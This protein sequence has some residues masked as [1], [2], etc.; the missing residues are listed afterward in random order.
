MSPEV[1]VGDRAGKQVSGWH[2]RDFCRGDDSQRFMGENS[3][4]STHRDGGRGTRRL[5]R[6][7]NKRRKRRT[8]LGA[9]GFTRCAAARV[10]REAEVATNVHVR[11]MDL[12]AFGRSGLG[13]GTIR[14]AQG[15]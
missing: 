9:G 8:P 14:R 15:A 10:Y 11:D 4:Q 5:Q 6:L 2:G 13:H 7:R 1:R 12:A 3:Q